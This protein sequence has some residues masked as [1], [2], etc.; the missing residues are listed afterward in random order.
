MA[1]IAPDGVIEIF[2]DVSLSSGQEDTLYFAST[3]AKDTYFNSLNKLLSLS[4]QSYTRKERGSIRVE[5]TMAQLYNACYMRYRNASFENKWFYAFILSVDYI[6]NVTVEIKFE[7]DVMMTWMGAFSLAQCFVERQH[8]VSDAIGANLAEENLD[9]GD[10]VY[11]S[12]SRSNKL[13]NYT[14]LIGASVDQNGDPVAGGAMVNNIYSGIVI[15]QFGTVQAANAFIDSLTSK[16]ASNAL[17]ACVM[18]PSKFV[19]DNSGVTEIITV[20]KNLSSIDGYVPRNKKLFTYPYNYLVVTNGQG[21]YATFRYE[22]WA[23]DSTNCRFSLGG[24]AGLQPCAV[25]TPSEYK[26]SAQN[27]F[28]YAEQ[29]TL[30]NFPQCAFNIDQYKAFLAQNSASIA[31]DAVS[32]V[33]SGI[34]STIG[35]ALTGN[36]FGAVNSAVGTVE[37]VAN[38]VAYHVDYAKKPPQSNG[39]TTTD[40]D[41]SR[42]EKDFWFLKQSITRNYAKM[43]DDYF[44]MFGYAV[45]EVRTPNMNARPY[46]TYVKTIDCVVHGNIPSDDCRAI[47]NLFNR[48]V[49]FWKNHTQIGNYSLNNS[50]T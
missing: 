6:N 22:F 17:V 45:R 27:L 25:L 32:T 23:S 31:V 36:V 13:G 10:Y 34:I 19:T 48:G 30:N 38:T 49:R 28:N 37:R 35:N 8:T 18:C 16:A 44:T 41:A 14:I 4:A 7:I 1:Y 5:A 15:H 21:N 12:I 40:F 47:E 20:P 33:G 29:I 39:V 2:G 24:I 26:H 50:P 9:L 43:I 42:R 11:N 46:F 3:S